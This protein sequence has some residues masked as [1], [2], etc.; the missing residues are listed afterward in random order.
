MRTAS[1]IIARGGTSCSVTMVM[2]GRRTS[3]L[4]WLVTGDL[5]YRI[6]TRI[7]LYLGHKRTVIVLMNGKE[8]YSL[9]SSRAK[10][11]SI[12]RK[13]LCRY[14]ECRG[15]AWPRSHLKLVYNPEGVRQDAWKSMNAIVKG[16]CWENQWQEEASSAQ[17]E[18]RE[19]TQLM[20]LWKTSTQ[21]VRDS[22]RLRRL[23]MREERGE[24]LRREEAKSKGINKRMGLN[25]KNFCKERFLICSRDIL[26]LL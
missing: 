25:L 20:N 22:L 8:R 17:R 5:G 10:C 4:R 14:S 26:L 11:T 23:S 15:W 18:S 1:E 3:A 2:K 6:R 9:K 12:Q 21:K 16:W 19:Y 7:L 24:K 13:R